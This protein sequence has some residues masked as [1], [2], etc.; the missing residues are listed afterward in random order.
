MASFCRLA[1]PINN[2]GHFLFM[3]AKDTILIRKTCFGNPIFAKMED[4]DVAVS[5]A[6]A[7]HSLFP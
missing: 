7:C 1:H 3:A 4:L 5:P 6:P 2:Q